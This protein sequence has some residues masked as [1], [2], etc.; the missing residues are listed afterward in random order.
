MHAKATRTLLRSAIARPETGGS[1]GHK[2]FLSVLSKPQGWGPPA[3]C[4]SLQS[5]PPSVPHHM[6]HAGA[7]SVPSAEGGTGFHALTVRAPGQPSGCSQG[8]LVGGPGLGVR[9]T[10]VTPACVALQSGE[11]IS[12]HPQHAGPEQVAAWPKQSSLRLEDRPGGTH[13]DRKWP[14]RPAVLVSS[15]TLVFKAAGGSVAGDSTV[16]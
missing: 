1:W 11:G 4:W 3:G 14:W 16:M 6:F 2:D 12:C 10:S 7:A 15:S 8:R 9:A 13:R 5:Q